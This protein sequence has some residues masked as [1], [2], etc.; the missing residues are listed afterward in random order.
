[1]IQVQKVRNEFPIFKNQPSVV[2]LDSTATTLKPQQVLDAEDSYYK[3]YTANVF[4]GIYRLSE[5]ATEAYENARAIIAKF[6]GASDPATV[7]F[8]RNSTESLNLLAYT[9]AEK[10]FTGKS[11]VVVSIAEHHANFVPWQQLIERMGGTF[12][13]T[14]I[15]D[16]TG[17]SVLEDPAVIDKVVTKN[18]A[19]VAF[20]MASN[21]LGSVN[22]VARITKLVKEKNP[23]ALVIVD[24]AQAITSLP[25]TVDKW[26][27][28]A[29][30]FSG[31]KM[32]G[33]TGTGVVWA[34]RELLE[35]LPPFLYG[36]EMIETVAIEKTTFA[37][38]PNKF[39]AGT[40]HIAGAIGLGAAVQ[41]ITSYGVSAIH[42]HITEITQ[43]ALDALAPF[44]H[45]HVIG[46]KKAKDRVGLIA[47]THDQI[48][49]HDLS[50]LLA[51]REVCIRAGH[52]CAM[53][54]HTYLNIPASAR[55]SFSIYTNKADIDALVAGIR[56][57]EKVL[58]INETKK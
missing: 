1:M 50:A 4:R 34:K 44:S 2:Y 19:V 36:G 11:R 52:H 41:Y 8:T 26:G 17:K 53:P 45:I 22:D 51:Q 58:K 31:H 15:D 57:A 47:F 14:G 5:E 13:V 43:Y 55:A 18:T 3:N 35:A 12:A 40:P 28:D 46:P 6:I 33:P 32:Y 30:V 9:I 49:P 16:K 48:H 20:F 39:E 7:V 10:Y 54:L 23:K 56:H 27:I 24:A 29:L 42:Q 38:L 37:P 25:I 21:V